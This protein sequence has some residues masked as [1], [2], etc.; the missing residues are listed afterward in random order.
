MITDDLESVGYEVFCAGPS[1][2]EG[3]A[4]GRSGKR[5]DVKVGLSQA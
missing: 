1:G 4:D 3:P 2:V 5:I